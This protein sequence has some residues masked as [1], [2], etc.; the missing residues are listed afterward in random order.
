MKG[1]PDYVTNSRGTLSASGWKLF[2]R[3]PQAGEPVLLPEMG[4]LGRMLEKG[5]TGVGRDRLFFEI[6]F[7][8][9]LLL[10]DCGAIGLA[11]EQEQ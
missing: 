6:G 9:A 5:Q 8:F 11:G 2:V 4:A 3:G 1:Q 10:G 7:R